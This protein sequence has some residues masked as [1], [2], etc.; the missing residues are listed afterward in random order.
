MPRT[1]TVR[2]GPRSF[3]VVAPQIWNTLPSHLKNISISREQ[4]KSGLKTWLFV[5]AYSL[6]APLRSGALQM[7]DLIWLIDWVHVVASTVEFSES[8]IT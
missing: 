7:L 5:Q 8:V 4:F 1:Q 3:R 6:E 2:Y